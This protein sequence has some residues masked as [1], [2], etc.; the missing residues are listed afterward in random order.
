MLVESAAQSAGHGCEVSNHG[1]G[2]MAKSARDKKSDTAPKL[3]DRRHGDRRHGERRLHLVPALNPE[4][5]KLL[6]AAL[7]SAPPAPPAQMGQVLPPE[8]EPETAIQR[9]PVAAPVQVPGPK[10]Y[11]QTPRQ[12][13]RVGLMLGAGWLL[14]SELTGPAER[15]QRPRRRLVRD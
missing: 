2:V 9:T 4:T 8:S 13:L 1:G 12:V 14:F 15:F 10:V 5:R 7:A 11:G 3:G 6:L